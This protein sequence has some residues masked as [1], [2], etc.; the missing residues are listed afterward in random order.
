[1]RQLLRLLLVASAFF[2]LIWEAYAA[3][4]W[5]GQAGGIRPAA[6]H[7]WNTLRSDWMTLIVVSDHLV[8][9]GAVLIALWVDATRLGWLLRRRVLLTI[10]FVG[11][12]SPTL[13]VYLAWRIG[14]SGC[15]TKG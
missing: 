11:L 1:M 5:I 7:F 10:A 2:F 8:I 6:A 4:R 12:G 3:L 15:S 13:L 9:A 14:P